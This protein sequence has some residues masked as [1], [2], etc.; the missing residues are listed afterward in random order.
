M[1]IAIGQKPESDFRNPLGLLSDC[2]RRIERFLNVLLT[3]ARQAN[4]NGLDKEQHQ[5]LEVALRY[6]REAAPK[7]TRDEEE[8]LFPRIRAQGSTDGDAALALLDTLHADH[9]SAGRSHKEVDELGCRWLTDGQLPAADV[10]LLTSLLESLR[11]TY[12]HHIAIED[13]Q[14]F[15]LAERILDRAELEAVAREMAARRGLIL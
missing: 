13:S 11:E 10:R 1:P 6:F 12:Q 2:H 4:G 14:V 5:A 7:H 8:S 3:V 9:K 15:P